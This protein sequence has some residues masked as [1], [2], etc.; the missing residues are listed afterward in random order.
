MD[1]SSIVPILYFIGVTIL[2]TIVGRKLF[3]IAY[4]Q[5]SILKFILLLI[6]VC[7]G[8]I[9]LGALILNIIE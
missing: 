6:I 1:I 5:D 7:L 9:S 8:A 4:E 3:T 2:C